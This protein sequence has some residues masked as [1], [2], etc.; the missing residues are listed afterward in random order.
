MQEQALSALQAAVDH[1]QRPA[2]P[3]ALIAGDVCTLH[4]LHR[5]KLL[6]TGKVKV[7]SASAASTAPLAACCV[8]VCQS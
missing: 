8:F 2:F 5:L 4:L 7:R 1:F 3:C 6:S